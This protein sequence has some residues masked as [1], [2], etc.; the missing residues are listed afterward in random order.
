MSTSPT[1][2]LD[3]PGLVCTAVTEIL[4]DL[5]A[6][7]PFQGEFT[8]AEL[9]KMG[10]PTP[11][12]LISTLRLKQARD[13]AGRFEEFHAGMVAYVITKDR[14]GLDRNSAAT[15]IVQALLEL[16][17]GK[18]WDNDA[19]G[20]AREVIARP[21]ITKETRDNGVTLWLVMWVQPLT[22]DGV[23]PEALPI[24]LYVGQSPEI[25]ADHEGDYELIGDPS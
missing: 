20:E 5:K 12:V 14:M 3:L 23:S 7:D 25:G 17:P 9:K 22:F 15:S 18:T 4:P 24:E 2:L 6:C 13:L 8:F 10:L 19:L 1:L 16:I 11:A 21:A